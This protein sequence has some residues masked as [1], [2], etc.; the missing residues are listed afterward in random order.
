MSMTYKAWQNAS[1]NVMNIMYRRSTYF[2]SDLIIGQNISCTKF[3]NSCVC[4]R[5]TAYL[6]SIW[7]RNM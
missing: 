6:C 3:W 2:L 5:H 1:H 4:T 7:A